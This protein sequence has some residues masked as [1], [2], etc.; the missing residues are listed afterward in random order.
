MKKN[1]NT[2]E[3]AAGQRTICEHVDVTQPD[4][5]IARFHCRVPAPPQAAAHQISNADL[6]AGV[7]IACATTNRPDVKAP[8][9]LERI[10]RRMVGKPVT[11]D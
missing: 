8:G 7:T 6:L 9:L 10:W 5:S 2:E 11:R 4:G 3:L 1:V